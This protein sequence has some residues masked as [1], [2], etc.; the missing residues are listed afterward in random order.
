MFTPQSL[1]RSLFC[2][3][4]VLAV[5]CC[6]ISCAS[7]DGY[8]IRAGTPSSNS[9]GGYDYDYDR[10]TA[11]SADPYAESTRRDDY[12]SPSGPSRGSGSSY[13]PAPRR[14]EALRAGTRDDN[15]KRDDYLAYVDEHAY[16]SRDRVEYDVHEQYTIR[17]LDRSG[18]KVP[19]ALVRICTPRGNQ[20]GGHVLHSGLTAP[21]GCISFHP[22]AI[23]DANQLDAFDVM[24][25]AIGDSVTARFERN[26][27][28]QRN[29]SA[30]VD[31]Y[32]TQNERPAERTVPVQIAFLLDTTGSMA[33]EIASLQ[34]ALDS[35]VRRIEQMHGGP[36]VSLG[37]V[38]YRDKG[39]EYVT[40]RYDF[41]DSVDKFRR[42]LSQ[43]RAGGGGDTPEDVQRGL[44]E[45]VRHLSWSN[46][47]GVSLIF[48]VG[49]AEP[50][51]YRD[52]PNVVQS[53]LEAIRRGIVIH[54]L[55]ASGLE[56]DGEFAFR[57]IAQLTRGEFIFL[58]Y[59]PADRTPHDVGEAGVDFASNRLDDVIVR[60][61]RRAVQNWLEE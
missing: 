46:G 32:L 37:L 22:R 19:G 35:V 9:A 15:D 33:D 57:Q 13:Q 11:N 49:D 29:V 24:V 50:K 14:V 7:E 31:V 1:V 42:T 18:R 4:S 58:T 39:D 23:R 61:V 41:T 44:D 54:T 45:A 25:N 40:Q 48:L 3:L 12:A 5:A 6:L 17:V 38:L 30:R 43:V 51:L 27:R 47:E 52:C 60:C 8:S 34:A 26:S 56:A 2:G 59:G 16:R 21:D 53:S 55:A 20:N 10:G 28:Q 36:A